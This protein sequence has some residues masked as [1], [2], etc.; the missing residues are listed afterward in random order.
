[1]AFSVPLGT[2]YNKHFYSQNNQ[3][4]IVNKNSISIQTGI[5]IATS[6]LKI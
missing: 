5:I 6:L 3:R 1:M 2:A 4:A